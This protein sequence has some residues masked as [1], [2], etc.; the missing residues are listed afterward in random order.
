[1]MSPPSPG[2]GGSGGTVVP[3][4]GTLTAGTWDDNLNFDFYLRYLKKTDATQA[5]GLPLIPR[6]DRVAIEVTGADGM[7]VSGAEVRV[8]ADAGR[9]FRGIT[10][11]DG[12][13]MYFPAW[14]GVPAGM[15]L[16]VTATTGNGQVTAT[17]P[18]SGGRVALKLAQASGGAPAGLDLAFMIDTTG[19][20][21]DEIRYLQAEVG[22]ISDAL[23]MQFPGV[24]RRWGLVV[25][26][27]DG[28]EYVVRSF[29]FTPDLA[30]FR[31]NLG[32][33]S[34]N[35][36]GD[37]PEA[38]EKGLAATNAL[39]WRAG[40]TARV[41]FWVAD[42][43]HHAGRESLMKDGISDAVNKGVHIYPVAASGTDDLAE[44]T[45]RAAA[46]VTGGRYV[47]LTDDSGIGDSHKE[48]RIPCYFVTSL[49]SAMKRM[50]TMELSGVYL[51]PATAEVIRT[52]GAP[53]DKQ[54]CRLADGEIVAAF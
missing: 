18:V 53:A 13:V 46:Q 38:P 32:A 51:Q 21:G 34:A 33:Q 9:A 26:R 17:V 52:G 3:R 44:Y 4:P 43:P 10:G 2:S 35:G 14:M 28:D 22:Q 30:L 40:N 36:G 20:M 7:P 31:R 19:S 8:L 23:A 37:Y 1:M 45:M 41:V 25:Y 39:S 29:D 6:A 42:A 11:A 54:Q 5:P 47:F 16:T 15:N 12:R 24:S 27:D 48:P 49:Q 50:L